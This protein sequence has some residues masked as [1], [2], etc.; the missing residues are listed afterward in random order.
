MPL[1]G[2]LMRMWYYGVMSWGHEYALDMLRHLVA[3]R[4]RTLL[5][6]RRISA[7]E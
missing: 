5:R 4:V 7:S 2:G 1:E 3:M 6:E